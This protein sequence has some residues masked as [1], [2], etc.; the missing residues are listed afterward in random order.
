M[1]KAFLMCAK[2]HVNKAF[3]LC[4]EVLG[5]IM[6]LNYIKVEC[7]PLLSKVVQQVENINQFHLG[8]FDLLVR[9]PLVLFWVLFWG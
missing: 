3:V 5:D 7:V 9:T 2:T 4:R 1:N 6:V 8:E